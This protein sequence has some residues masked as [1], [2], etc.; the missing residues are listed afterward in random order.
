MGALAAL[1]AV[2]A[3][4]VL[5]ALAPLVVVSALAAPA[6]EHTSRDRR[7]LGRVGVLKLHYR[8]RFGV[9]SC[10]LRNIV[11]LFPVRRP[12]C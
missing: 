10:L 2:A 5:S 1:S 4:A 6:Q 9:G 8:D 11:A 3:F 12:A 7:A